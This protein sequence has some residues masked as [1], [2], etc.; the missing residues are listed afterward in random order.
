ME[1]YGCAGTNLGVLRFFF[2]NITSSLNDFF[3]CTVEVEESSSGYRSSSRCI[4]K[5]PECSAGK[6]AD[7]FG[8]FFQR[9]Q[10]FSSFTDMNSVFKHKQ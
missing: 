5:L 10:C 2:V 1:P 7:L 4:E 6:K 9:K 8:F 3:P